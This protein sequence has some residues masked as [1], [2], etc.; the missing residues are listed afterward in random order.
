MNSAIKQSQVEMLLGLTV[1]KWPFVQTILGK[2]NSS[3]E[4]KFLTTLSEAHL[5]T[6]PL[7]M[8]HI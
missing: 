4:H 2:Q 3:L 1:F 6:S 7:R 8:T 5:K